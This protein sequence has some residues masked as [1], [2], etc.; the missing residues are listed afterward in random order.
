MYTTK[1]VFFNSHLESTK[2]ASFYT[3]KFEMLS[4]TEED[5]VQLPPM[6]KHSK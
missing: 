2:E 1:V 6:Y 3:C 4:Y 5:L